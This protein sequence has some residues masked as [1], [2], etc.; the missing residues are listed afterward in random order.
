M[1][2]GRK[3]LKRYP[4]RKLRKTRSTNP[5]ST[6]LASEMAA[7]LQAGNDN[8]KPHMALIVEVLIPTDLPI[9]QCEIEVIAALLEDSD[10]IFE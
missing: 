2:A 5:V 6:G 3:P 7:P 9:L 4:G 10:W 8:K 1:A